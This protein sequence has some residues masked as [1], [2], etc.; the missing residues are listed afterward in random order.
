[1]LMVYVQGVGSLGD[2]ISNGDDT[3]LCLY[4]SHSP[5]FLDKNVVYILAVS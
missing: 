2:I 5:G 3:T 4:Y 1:M